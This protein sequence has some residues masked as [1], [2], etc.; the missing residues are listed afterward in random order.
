MAI[1][2]TTREAEIASLID[3]WSEGLRTKDADRVISAFAEDSVMFVLA[4]P[5]AF[6]AATGPGRAGVEEWFA[7]WDGQ[8]G[9]ESRDLSITASEDVAFAHS[10]DH[11]QGAKTDGETVD[12]WFRTTL[13]LRKLD[14]EWKIAHQHQ[15]VPFYMDT[16]KAAVDLKP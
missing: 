15:S 14:G 12:M 2:P 9:L 6:T 7:S 13:G 11:L 10:L 4:P 3:D 5:L 8:L 16:Q 1:E